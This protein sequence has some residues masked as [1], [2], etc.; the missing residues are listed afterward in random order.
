LRVKSQSCS[1]G[2][3]ERAA[4]RK[5]KPDLTPPSGD[6]AIMKGAGNLSAMEWVL[7]SSLF[8]IYIFCLFTVC[9]LTFRKGHTVLGIVGIFVPLLWL[10]GAVLPPKPGSALDLQE[11][12]A[13]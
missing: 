1:C 12:R 9:A 6:E 8:I 7:W 2:G 5:Q 4:R 10:I 13:S 3:I 11:R